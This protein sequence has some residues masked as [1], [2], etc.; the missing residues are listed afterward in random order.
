MLEIAVP[1]YQ[2][3]NF[4]NLFKKLFSSNGTKINSLS[5]DHR[6]TE[7]KEYTRVIQA[8]GKIYQMEASFQKGGKQNSENIVGPL[9]VMPGKLSVSRA[10]GNIEAKSPLFNGNPNV[11]IAKPDIKYFDINSNYDFV[12]IG[13]D[14]IFE[15]FKNKEI[16]EIL[17]K[18]SH[19][20]TKDIHNKCGIL[21]DSVIS[22]CIRKKFTDNLTCVLISFKDHLISNDINNNN[23]NDKLNNS[24]YRINT[25]FVKMKINNNISYNTDN[26]LNNS[27]GKYNANSDEGKSSA[28]PMPKLKSLKELNFKLNNLLIESNNTNTNTNTNSCNDNICNSTNN[29]NKDNKGIFKN[30]FRNLNDNGDANNSSKKMDLNFIKNFN[31]NNN[32]PSNNIER[33]VK[34]NLKEKNDN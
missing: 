19:K 9:R 6:P 29:E 13:C 17:W 18:N 7:E 10:F 14:G 25:D 21:I 1:Y 2:G 20:E 8:G 22:E 26:L 32:A 15:G 11:I 12:F 16:I 28:L 24:K 5:K 3:K 4:F 27:N 23:N 34:I 30:I 33:F 31:N